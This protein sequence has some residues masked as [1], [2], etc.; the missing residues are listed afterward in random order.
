M[1]TQNRGAANAEMFAR[2]KESIAQDMKARNIGAIIWDN[3]SANFHQ[4]PEIELVCPS[5]GNTRTA[6]I[7][8]LY[9]YKD[10]VYLMEEDSVGVSVGDFYDQNTEVK[11]TVVT[12]TPDMA[13]KSLGDPDREDGY[14]R[15]GTL[16]EWT[17]V[18]DAYFEA[19]AEQ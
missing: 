19:L 2:A 9:L 17:V 8:G 1:N 7:T 4:I 14:T 18:A 5:T 11:P 12:L 16:E 6:R 10:N 13:A 3:A 15:Q